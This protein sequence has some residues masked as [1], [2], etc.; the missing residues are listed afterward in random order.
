MSLLKTIDTN[1]SFAPRESGPPP[2]RL[3]SGNP[4]FKTWGAGC[5]PRRDGS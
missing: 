2:E 4:A 5:R 3:I 1:P